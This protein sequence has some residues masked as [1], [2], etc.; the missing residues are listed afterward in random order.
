MKKKISAKFIQVQVGHEKNNKGNSRKI[1]QTE[2]PK[3]PKYSNLKVQKI[4]A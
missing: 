2:K 3:S 1:I 4:Y